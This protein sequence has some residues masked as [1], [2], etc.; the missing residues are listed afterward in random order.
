MIYL[1]RLKNA[2]QDVVHSSFDLSIDEVLKME[3]PENIIIDKTD[4]SIFVCGPRGEGF[5][6]YDNT[7]FIDNSAMI[8]TINCGDEWRRVIKHKDS[9]FMV[10]LKYKESYLKI[11]YGLLK[12]SIVSDF[13]LDL[14][15]PL[16]GVVWDDEGDNSE[17]EIIE[18]I[19]ESPRVITYYARFNGLSIALPDKGMVDLDT[20][21]LYDLYFNKTNDDT[22]VLLDYVKKDNNSVS[23]ET[24]KSCDIDKDLIKPKTGVF[25]F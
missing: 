8:R 13:H 1:K 14:Q 5:T 7:F 9:F 12:E 2:L 18:I 11:K 17:E 4:G 23:K 15:F 6:M 20:E 19:E 24:V 22:P 10:A 25:K 21:L 3:A 16:K